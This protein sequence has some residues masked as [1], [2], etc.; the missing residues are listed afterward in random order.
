MVHLPHNDVLVKH[1][2]SWYI[3]FLNSIKNKVWQPCIIPYP[4][5]RDQRKLLC[6]QTFLVRLW[7]LFH[8]EDARKAYS[9][10]NLGPSFLELYPFCWFYW[11]PFDRSRYI[12]RYYL[13]IVHLYFDFEGRPHTPYYFMYDGFRGACLWQELFLVLRAVGDKAPYTTMFVRGTDAYYAFISL[14][15]LKEIERCTSL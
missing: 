4:E 12:I 8:F 2:A 14:V 13:G 10:A 11:Y 9:S 1:F 5:G 7:H 15:K 6:I 3:T